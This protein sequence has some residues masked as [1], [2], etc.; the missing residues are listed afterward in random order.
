MKWPGVLAYAIGDGP[1]SGRPASVIPVGRD[2]S[3]RR[4][5][6]LKTRQDFNIKTGL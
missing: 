3:S 4:N 6:F 1:G 5:S 2:T